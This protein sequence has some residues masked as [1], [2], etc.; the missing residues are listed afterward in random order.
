[1]L[2]ACIDRS[3]DRSHYCRVKR[4]KPVGNS[5][6]IAIDRQEILYEIICTQTEKINLC[7][8]LIHHKDRGRYFDHGTQSG[9]A[10]FNSFL[11]QQVPFF[12][13][14]LTRLMN[15]RDVGDHWEDNIDLSTAR[16]DQ[17]RSQL[18]TKVLRK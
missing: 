15:F 8:Y 5:L 16:G 11:R 10:A 3:F 4:L 2:P 9:R 7:C 6:I 17:D 14:K 13:K 1:M 18:S 12:F